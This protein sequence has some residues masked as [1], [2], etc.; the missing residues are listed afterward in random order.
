MCSIGAI[1][2]LGLYFWLMSRS[3]AMK[4]EG[5]L[6]LEL[7]ASF[8]LITVPYPLYNSTKRREM[9]PNTIPP[10][11]L[12]TLAEYSYDVLPDGHHAIMSCINYDLHYACPHNST[13][14]LAQIYTSG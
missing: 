1:S 6:L 4:S 12:Y 5:V 8:N 10:D 11:R 13:N 2:C 7:R 14:V 3:L 9:Y